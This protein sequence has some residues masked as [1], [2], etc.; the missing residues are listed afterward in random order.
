M[1][2]MILAITIFALASLG[3]IFIFG[4]TGERPRGEFGNFGERV[5]GRLASELDL[6]NEQKNQIRAIIADAK[7]R[8][9]PLKEAMREQRRQ[10]KDFGTDGTFDEARVA[11]AAAAQ[12][13][14]VRQLILE[15]EKTKAAVFAVLTPEQRARAAELKNRFED[16]FGDRL[17]K[18]FGGDGDKEIF[19]QNVEAN[20]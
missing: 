2:K 10:L 14:A 17:K 15:K 3:G 19:E 20:R 6:T 12:A 4:Q 5:F 13:D 9:K 8:V 1:K 7:T 16:K 18:R 11:A